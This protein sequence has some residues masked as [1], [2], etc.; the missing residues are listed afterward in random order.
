MNYL[1]AD[2]ISKS[3]NDRWLFKDLTLGISA[4]EK[5]ALVG[6]N[7]TGKTTLLKILTGEIPSDSGTVSFRDGVRLGYLTQQPVA[8]GHLSIKEI[9]FDESNAVAAAVMRYE[10]CIHNGDTSPEDM[11]AALEKMEELNA[12][13]FDS[14]VN[15]IT[16]KLGITNFD[17]KFSTLSG[18][19]RKRIFMAKMLLQDPS[20]LI[21][22]EPT[23]HLDLEAI[24]WLE[25]Y[26]SG[27]NITLIMVTHDRYFLDNVANTIIELDKGKLYTYKGNYAYFLEKKSERE[28]I[29]KV[30]VSKAR[31]LLKKELEWMRRQP[32]ARGTKA[33]Y[34]I[35]AFHELKDKASQNL[36]KD[37]MELDIQ[38][39]RQGGKII[40][41]YN[42]S[43]AY[44]DKKMVDDFSYIFKKKDRIGI[45]G[46]NGVGKSTF[47][48]LLTGKSKPDSGE[49]LPG[50]TTKLGYFT[51]E[52]S[53]LNPDHRV[54]E[55]V[56]GIA[57]FIAL[58]DGTQISA[59]AFLELFLFPPE[60]QYNIIGKL[61]GGE[62]KRLQLLKV[63]I[64]N[65]NFLVLDEPTN[66]FDI[67][68]L[69][70]LEDFLDKFTGCLVLVSHDRYFMDHLVN[71][72]FVFEGDGKIK[73][74]NGNY[75]DYK[76]YKEE[77]EATPVEIK[78]SIKEKEEAPSTDA[79]RKI[80]FTEKKEHELL[81]KEIEA[82]EK[83]KAELVEKLSSGALETEEL[84]NCSK[85][86]KVLTDTIDSKTSRWL[87]LED[88]G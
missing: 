70:V 34:R 23:N 78:K 38:K 25:N 28:E 48:D 17:Q 43:K 75:S 73:V 59:S 80:S 63:L 4:G 39:T 58:A 86:I 44:G 74:M 84:V 27:Q 16:S 8:Q 10:A 13:E 14:K 42:V 56:K 22:D 2:Q 35:E 62:K 88:F 20:I 47:L 76:S 12:W 18:G 21:M 52:A 60:K 36:K 5:F 65:P 33:K 9:L 79:K 87:E 19:Q 67:E 6:E 53:E 64:T 7:G 57:E 1:S 83:E 50:Q 51:Q 40:E 82:M 81:E 31:N 54:I 26:L 29:L 49:I 32:R 41:L 3:Y 61:S 66:D 15:E 46:S 11:Q 77:E 37:R 72:L 68:T 55:E 71:Q 45:V 30:E 69:N 85:R 24:E